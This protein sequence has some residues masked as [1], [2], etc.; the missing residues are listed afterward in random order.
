MACKFSNGRK[1]RCKGV[2][3]HVLLVSFTLLVLAPDYSVDG[4]V[5]QPRIHV[6]E[7][8]AKK[9]APAFSHGSKDADLALNKI[10]RNF[11]FVV[12]SLL[13]FDLK[14]NLHTWPVLATGIERSPPSA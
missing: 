8:N 10:A 5:R 4:I 13:K 7:E 9:Y 6:A 14:Q 11:T 2:L 3:L 1:S 12:F